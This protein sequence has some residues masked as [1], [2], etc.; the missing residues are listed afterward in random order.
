MWGKTKIE[1]YVAKVQVI[2]INASKSICI[3]FL[4]GKIPKKLLKKNFQEKIPYKLSA[5]LLSENNMRQKRSYQK[6][7]K[8]D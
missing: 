2:T 6:D 7:E 5:P 4:R 1:K 3:N 8:N